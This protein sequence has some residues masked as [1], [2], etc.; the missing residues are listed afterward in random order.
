M[1]MGH[2]NCFR[3]HLDQWDYS[4]SALESRFLV[5]PVYGLRA[6]ITRQLSIAI[7]LPGSSAYT[8]S[9]DASR[10]IPAHSSIA[11]YTG[12]GPGDGTRNKSSS[13]AWC[14]YVPRVD[15]VL[16]ASTFF[17]L[18]FSATANPSTYTCSPP[19][20]LFSTR[21]NSCSLIP[22]TPKIKKTKSNLT[23]MGPC[24]TYCRDATAILLASTPDL[25][26]QTPM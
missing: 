13:P 17:F 18:S 4:S 9:D 22:P 7:R 16:Y 5:R 19:T 21:W 24:S 2:V 14:A 3:F 11:A 6:C 15:S 20:H 10:T 26:A 1:G 25:R 23:Q 8:T 12:Y